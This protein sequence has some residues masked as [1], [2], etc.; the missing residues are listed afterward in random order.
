MDIAFRFD[1]KVEVNNVRDAI[2]VNS[3]CSDIRCYQDLYPFATEGFQRPLSG[4]LRFVT[5]QRS[6]LNSTFYEFFRKHVCS[7]FGLCEH[8]G[9]LDVVGSQEFF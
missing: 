4:V 2:N 7:S 8:Q 3:A 5:V 9:T 1:R 6:G